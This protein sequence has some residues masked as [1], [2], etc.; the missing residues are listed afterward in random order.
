[1][2]L[3]TLQQIRYELG[4]VDVA[5]PIMSDSEYEYFL[6]K[7]NNSVR[8]AALDAAKTILFKLSMKG[9]HS[10]DILSVKGS[11]A[12]EAY[13]MALQLYIKNPDL[14]TLLQN[15]SGYAGGISVSDMQSNINDLDNNIVQSPINPSTVTTTFPT[16]YFSV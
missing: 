4:D 6:E 13:R 8:R 12:A 10:V 14:N 2:P 9:D 15:A 5:L 3:T 11:K 16:D 7:N 1:M